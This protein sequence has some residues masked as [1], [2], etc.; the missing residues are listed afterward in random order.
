MKYR[1]QWAL[2]GIGA[3]FV[4]LLFSFPLYHRLL[5]GTNATPG[6]FAFANDDQ[7]AAFA[8]MLKDRDKRLQAYYAMLTTV[9]A[10]TETA[11][12]LTDATAL[13]TGDFST[14]DAVRTGK[15]TAT[16]Y[17]SPNDQTLLKFEN[18]SVTN[19]PHLAVYLC[20]ASAPQ[21]MVG[22]KGECS[23]RTLFQV[24]ALKGTVGD[25]FYI[26]PVELDLK[27]FKS[28][29]IYSQDLDLIYT[30]APLQ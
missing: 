28:V 25:Q 3:I 19:A 13:L 24:A 29:V 7:V 27:P 23:E 21:V 20:D 8:K 16:I 10:P 12:D 4:A 9:P 11:P 15:G 18:F 26:L 2:L 17:R 22:D 6:A 14:L 5:T 30:T 1:P